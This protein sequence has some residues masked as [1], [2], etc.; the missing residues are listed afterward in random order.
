VPISFYTFNFTVL[1]SWKVNEAIVYRD[2]A[3]FSRFNF[4]LEF[5]LQ[6]S[7]KRE[8]NHHESVSGMWTDVDSRRTHLILT[9]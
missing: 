6:V 3:Q 8:K 7:D 2:N 1:L 9:M 5:H 4:T